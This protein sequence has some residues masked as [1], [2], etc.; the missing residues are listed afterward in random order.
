MQLSIVTNGIAS[1]PTT[2]TVLE[3]VPPAVY[4][5]Q[6]LVPGAPPAGGHLQWYRHDGWDDGTFHWTGPTT[7]GNSWAG[8][9]TVFSGGDRIIYA[10][11]EPDLVPV[12]TNGP[13]HHGDSHLLWFRHDGQSDGTFNWEGP[14]T[15]GNG[16]RDFVHVFSGG[17]G[18]IYAVN[19]DGALF[20]YRHLGH[21]DGTFN[22]EGPRQVGTGWAD[23]KQVFSGGDGVIYA[24]EQ[25][26]QPPIQIKDHP[27]PALGATSSGTGTTAGSTA[28]TTG[29]GPTS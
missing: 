8:F 10:I 21:G 27:P 25:Y 4:G 24:I 18:I 2:V 9:P 28:A 13:P 16:W 29:R 12:P 19:P 11:T 17:H 15:V 3:A 5:I 7:V 20:W 22:W 6:P 1:D 26:H 14:T 23:F